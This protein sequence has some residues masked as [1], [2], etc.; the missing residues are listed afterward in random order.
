M[1]T[2]HL[3]HLCRTRDDYFEAWERERG[4]GQSIPRERRHPHRLPVRATCVTNGRVQWIT[5]AKLADDSVKLAS[6]LPDDIDTVVAIPRSGMI[7]ASIVACLL[8]LPLHT[9]IDGKIV[10]CGHGHRLR[11]SKFCPKRIAFIDDTFAG[12]AAQRKLQEDWLLVEPHIHAVVYSSVDHGPHLYARHLPMPH[13]LEWNLFN[14]CYIP[15]IATDMDG[16]LCHNPPHGQIPLYLPRRQSI[17][18]IVTARPVT[19]MSE[20]VQWLA[21]HGVEY[22]QLSMWPHADESH[23][24]AEIAAWKAACVRAS[25][26]EWYVESE[27]GLA[28]LIRSHGL[29][30]LCPRQGYMA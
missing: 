22:E 3:H 21:A 18:A 2:E 23:N 5:V 17:C 29:R 30:V 14:S 7:P 10:P 24:T 13:L 25:G 6:L 15:S 20:T 4:P 8:H 11:D 26:A 28:D 19:E 27:P 1:K 9:I 12:G 16:I